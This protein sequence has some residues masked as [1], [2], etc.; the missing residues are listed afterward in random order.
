MA[1]TQKLKALL[2]WAR[3]P[4]LCSAPML[5]AATPRLAVQVSSAGGVGFI[6]AGTSFD[7][8]DQ[9]LTEIG[10]LLQ[11]Q[12]PV[13][14]CR[15]GILPIGVGF[16][17]WSVDVDIAVKAIKKHVPAIAW[18]F[19]PNDVR[20]YRHWA[21]ELRAAS[22]GRTSI[23]IQVGSVQEALQAT[24][25]AK[26]DVLVLQG[27]DAGGHGLCH[28][29]SVLT[30]VPETL[31]ALAAN[32]I[33]DV[34]V[35]AA[36]GLVEGRGMAA[37]VA[38]GAC[39]AVMGTRFLAASEAGIAKGWQREI[40]ITQDGGVTTTRSTL[41]DRLKETRGWP[42]HYDGRNIVNKGHEDEANGMPDHEQ[43]EIYKSELRTGDEA[44]G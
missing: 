3:A 16:Q 30:L 42:E 24:R 37:A 14:E 27:A 35:L 17:S 2:P 28:A 32:G 23:W 20:H 26:P 43:I 40:L 36:G 19:A 8:L 18:L 21:Q 7:G 13:I 5:N 10:S 44:W 11:K 31:E 29:G 15:E 22:E 39:G 38:L 4:L 1:G 25:V 6:A 12:D 33:C 34:P 9:S 41:C